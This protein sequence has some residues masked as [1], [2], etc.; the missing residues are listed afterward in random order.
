M[1]PSPFPP[2]LSLSTASK[3]NPGS[4]KYTLGKLNDTVC[5]H[6]GICAAWR[7]ELMWLG[8][9]GATVCGGH[10]TCHMTSLKFFSTCPS[11]CNGRPWCLGLHFDSKGWLRLFNQLFFF[12]VVVRHPYIQPVW[13]LAVTGWDWCNN[14]APVCSSSAP[15]LNSLFLSE[16]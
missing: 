16:S 11:D 13:Q 15:P 4:V 7:D 12:S 9:L 1:F 14:V 5:P 3:T 8:G 6:L 10:V 2:V